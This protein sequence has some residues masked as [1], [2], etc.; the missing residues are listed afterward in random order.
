MHS[1]DSLSP[2]ISIK[3]FA[4]ANKF[5]LESKLAVVHLRL[6]AAELVPFNISPKCTWK[7]PSPSFI[8]RFMNGMILSFTHLKSSPSKVQV[9]G[10]G[11]LSISLFFFAQSLQVD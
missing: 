4:G 3:F 10:H 11:I 2:L 5:A 8:L 6:F 1:F 7:A 9:L